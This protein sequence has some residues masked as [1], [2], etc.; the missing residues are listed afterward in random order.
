L[1]VTIFLLCAVCVLFGWCVTLSINLYNQ[2]KINELLIRGVEEFGKVT[3]LLSERA[4]R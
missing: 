1:E 2:A 3:H 4:L